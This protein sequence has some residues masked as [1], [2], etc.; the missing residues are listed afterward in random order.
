MC[1]AIPPIHQTPSRRGSYLS[2][3][4]ILQSNPVVH[5]VLEI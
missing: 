4:K 3:Q 1:G 5:K 2:T